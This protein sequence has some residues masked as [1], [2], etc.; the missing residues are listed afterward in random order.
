MLSKQLTRHALLIEAV[1]FGT[2]ASLIMMPFGFLFKGI[3]LRVGHYGPK[4]GEVLFSLSVA[5]MACQFDFC[6]K[7]ALINQ[8]L[9]SM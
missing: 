8:P 5:W 9:L 7:N 6:G 1:R 3:G 2:I 4:L